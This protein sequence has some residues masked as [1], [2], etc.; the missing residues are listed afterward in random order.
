ML[1][2]VDHGN[3]AIKT[4]QSIFVSGIAEHSVKPPLAE[5]VILYDGRYWT[6]TDSRIPYIRDKTRDERF[7]ILTLFALSRDLRG[8]LPTYADVD[9]AVGLPPEHYSTLK[10]KFAVTVQSMGLHNG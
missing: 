6:L 1:F 2:A 4:E 7:F 3:F 8:N 9:L 5:D 10:S